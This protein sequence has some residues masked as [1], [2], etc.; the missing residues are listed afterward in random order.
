MLAQFQSIGK[1]LDIEG[2]RAGTTRPPIEILGV[3][4]SGYNSTTLDASRLGESTRF[5]LID[6]L[7]SHVSVLT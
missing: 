5:V 1:G 7:E 3:R 4:I 6:H 2:F